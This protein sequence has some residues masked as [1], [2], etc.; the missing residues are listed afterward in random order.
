MAVDWIGQLNAN[1][2]FISGQST[3]THSM[4]YRTVSGSLLS[5]NRDV[6][7]P[8]LGCLYCHWIHRIQRIE[9][10]SNKEIGNRHHQ[11]DRMHQ[12]LAQIRAHVVFMFGHDGQV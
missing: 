10:Q 5:E 11:S 8:K 4:S 3:V 2:F 9:W 12:A 6:F 7:W 1:D